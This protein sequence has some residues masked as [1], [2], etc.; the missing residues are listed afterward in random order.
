MIS[1]NFIRGKSCRLNCSVHAEQ[2][3][4]NCLPSRPKNKKLKKCDLIVI[5]LNK[6]GILGMSK[7]CG[8]CINYMHTMASTKGYIIKNVRYSDESGKIVKV[9]LSKL[10]NEKIHHV[11]K[12]Y[13][14]RIA[15]NTRNNVRK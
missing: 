3:A 6:S 14:S 12:Y 10:I 7:P 11:S 8:V 9:K 5:R 4:I 2:H 13:K 15:Q 1:Y